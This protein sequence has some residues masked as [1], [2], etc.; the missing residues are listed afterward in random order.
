MIGGRDHPF[1][2][3]IDIRIAPARDLDGPLLGVQSRKH[4]HVERRIERMEHAAQPLCPVL[5]FGKEYDAATARLP[6]LFEQMERK[7]AE[8]RRKGD[9]RTR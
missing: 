2:I 3:L 5:I 9:R 4:K 8:R 7:H 6:P 1:A